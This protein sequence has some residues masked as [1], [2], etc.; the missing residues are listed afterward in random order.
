LSYLYHRGR[1][2][3]KEEGKI[4]ITYE[5][6]KGSELEEV[7]TQ[8]TVF[9]EKRAHKIDSKGSRPISS[10]WGNWLFL[11]VVGIIGAI[12]VGGFTIFAYRGFPTE[13][14]VE[15]GNS[16]YILSQEIQKYLKI[17]QVSNYKKSKSVL[18]IEE[19]HY[20]PEGQINL[21]KGLE[22]FFNEYP[23][24]VP[25]TIFLAE[26]L[27][28]NQH[29]SVKSLIDVEPNPDE[30][31]IKEVLNTFLITGYI[32]YEW[33]YQ[34]NIPIVGT[35]D[36]TLYNIS[37]KLW[38][39]LQ[40]DEDNEDLLNLWSFTVSAR[41]KK[42][43]QTLIEKTRSYDNPILFVG[44]KHLEKVFNDF[45]GINY[46]ITDLYLKQD[47]VAYLQNYEDLGIEDFLRDREIGFTFLAARSKPFEGERSVN[48]Y[49][50]L[51]KAQEKGDYSEYI[52]LL[53]DQKET[54][55]VT[56]AP[57]PKAA[58]QFV[59]A[60]AGKG[61]AGGKGKGEGKKGKKGEGSNGDGRRHTPEQQKVVKDA[62]NAKKKGGV[63]PQQAKELVDRAK[64]AG[65][66]ARGPESHPNRPYGKEPHIHIGPIDHI[67]VK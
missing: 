46:N 8:R 14:I 59:A 63:P 54:E 57:S 51:F 1:D 62:N 49:T 64:K 65:L 27:P 52:Q 10:L 19:P 47:E 56:V 9:E 36:K 4:K 67:P 26:G 25:K 37:A 24:L 48:L 13:K 5:D 42:I 60:M 12:L 23:E 40:E 6:L 29:L 35:E 41:N 30:K 18:I 50:R 32:A 39:N 43:A 3:L 61:K 66:P 44:G 20:S 31:L 16:N 33:K 22:R 15:I 11:I 45:H 53:V 21:Y 58:A 2:T 28:A 34:K 38:V 55:S 7:I 17:L